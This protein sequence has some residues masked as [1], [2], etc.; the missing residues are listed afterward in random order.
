LILTLS[1]IFALLLALIH[2]FGGR[3]RFLRVMPRSRW[4][5]GASG[6]SVAYVFVHVLPDLA[7]AQESVRRAAAGTAAAFLE[8][9]VYLLALVGMMAFYGLERLAKRSRARAAGQPGGDG[10]AEAVGPAADGLVL[11]AQ[12]R[13]ATSP[14]VFWIHAVSFAVY[15]ALIGYLLLHR[16]VPGVLSLSTFFAAMAT[17]FLVNDYGLREDHKGRYDRYG[18]WLLAAAV[19]VGWCVGASV[20]VHKAAV[21]MLFGFLAGGVVLNVLKEELPEE[22]QSNFF[23]FAGGAIGY[24]ALLLAM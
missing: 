1:A 18:R 9:H 3:L 19:L 11:A 8:H 4:L 20:E 21:G 15:N 10:S 2:V 6:V 22:R 17:H 5:S 13:T 7:D 24:T 12:R 16:E 23:A 14:G